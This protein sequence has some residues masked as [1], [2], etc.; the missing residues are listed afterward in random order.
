MQVQ[1]LSWAPEFQHLFCKVLTSLLNPH[2]KVK[3]SVSERVVFIMVRE[4]IKENWECLA[5]LVFD[6]PC[7]GSETQNS[8]IS[9]LMIVVRSAYQQ[10]EPSWTKLFTALAFVSVYVRCLL[11]ET[12]ATVACISKTLFHIVEAQHPN[13]LL[14]HR[15]F[16]RSLKEAYP[17]CWYVCTLQSH[18]KKIKLK[19]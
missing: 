1:N 2:Q 17:K 11:M 10:G 3:L 19:K 4:C 15:N 14:K 12:P 5:N 9:N 7:S 8:L 18:L 6:M 13:W 16:G